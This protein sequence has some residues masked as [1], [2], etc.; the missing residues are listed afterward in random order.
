MYDRETAAALEAVPLKGAP[1]P[2]VPA[3][4]GIVYESPLGMA[5]SHLEGHS[6][7]SDV[8][9]VLFQEQGGMGLLT[10]RMNAREREQ[11]DTFEQLMGVALP[12]RP[13]TS[14]VDGDRVIR[15]LSPDEWLMSV[16]RGAVYELHCRFHELM[17][18][19]C[20]LIDVSGGLAAWRLSG[21]K[22]TDL[23]RKCVPVDLHP[24]EFPVGKV[25]STVFAK[26]SCTLRREG[27]DTFELLVRRSYSDYCWRWVRDASREFGLKRCKG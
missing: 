19:H 17:P 18:G 1:I 27:I 21:D 24:L 5:A 26:S 16:P 2:Q 8:G 11:T 7:A 6:D 15:W 14:N 23:L 22:V 9:G 20:A 13:L 12:T 4:K 25:V 10:L 3:D